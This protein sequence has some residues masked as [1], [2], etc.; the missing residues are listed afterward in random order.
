MQNFLQETARDIHSKYS[1]DF[2]DVCLI[3]PNRRSGLFFKKHLTGLLE[4]PVWSPAI[5]TISDLMQQMSGL[6]SADQLSLIFM[7]HQIY[8][9]EKQSNETFDEFY[10]LIIIFFRVNKKSSQLF[11]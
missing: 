5:L 7:L 9:K 8:N 1:E 10:Y 3:F 4:K 6:E 2:A 11:E